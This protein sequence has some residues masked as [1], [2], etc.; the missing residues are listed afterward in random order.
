MFKIAS[1]QHP[2][3][4][5]EQFAVSLRKNKIDEI[6]VKRRRINVNPSSQESYTGSNETYRGAELEYDYFEKRIEELLP[7][8]SNSQ[9]VIVNTFF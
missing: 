5:R 6:L 2:Q 7:G 8:Y 3:K 1:F 4:K 9:V